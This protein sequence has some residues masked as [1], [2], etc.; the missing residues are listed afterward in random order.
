[1]YR[2]YFVGV[3]VIVLIG[4]CYFSPWITDNYAKS[5]AIAGF[6]SAWAKTIDGCGSK[7]AFQSTQV[8]FGRSVEIDYA[9]GL[10]PYDS[11]KFHHK[12]DV[13]V[14]FIGTVH[15]NKAVRP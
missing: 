10:L 12:T 2:G 1:M 3:G 15:I 13:F 8:P 6:N 7:Q 9:C 14:S 4:L 11:P 5:A